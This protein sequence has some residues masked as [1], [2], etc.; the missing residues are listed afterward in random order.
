MSLQNAD[1]IFIQWDIADKQVLRILLS[2]TGSVNRSGFG[3]VDKLSAPLCMGHLGDT[4][5]YDTLLGLIPDSW[6]D[7]AGRYTLPNAQGTIC[8]L[9]IGLEGET[10]DTGFAFTYGMDSDGPPEEFVYLVDLAMELTEPWYTEQIARKKQNKKS[11]F[12]HKKN[13]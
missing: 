10:I 11:S 1:R 4:T 3:D 8:T 9:S 7:M 13:G 5:A 2:R 12:R 6:I